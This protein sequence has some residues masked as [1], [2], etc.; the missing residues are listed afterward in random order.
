MRLI[1][2]HLTTLGETTRRVFLMSRFEGLTVKQISDSLAITPKAVEYH[3]TKALKTLRIGL[4]DM[5]V[6]A[7]FIWLT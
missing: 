2:Q 6:I 7:L 5:S 4:G 1:E 3:I